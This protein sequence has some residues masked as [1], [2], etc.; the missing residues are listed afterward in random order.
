MKEIPRS[1]EFP[2]KSFFLFGPR[3]V[4]KSSLLRRKLS[5]VSISIDLLEFDMSLDL[6]RNPG[7]LESLCGNLKKGDWIWIDEVQKVPNL[8]D[9]VHRLIE[10]RSWNFALSGSSA[11]KLKR[12]GANLLA[13]RALTRNLE[14]FTSFEL[15]DF[16]DL[17]DSLEYGTL[18]L[19]TTDPKNRTETLSAYVN[20]YIR[21]EI[22]EEGLVRKVD[23]FLRFLEIAGQLNGEQINSS[24]LAREARI[25]R[26]N[27]DVYFSILEDTLLGH[28][29]R[30]Y[31][32]KAKVKEQ[33]HPK[34]YWFDSGVARTAAGYLKETLEA[35]WIGKAL[36]TLLYHELR[37]Y[38]HVSRKERGIYFYKVDKDI[39]I[40]FVIETKKGTFNSQPE[41]V[42][43]EVKFAK[44][45]D[46]RWERPMQSLAS[47][48]KVKVK[49]MYG[50]Y[51]GKE[52]Y[53][54]GNVTILP[55]LEFLSRLHKGLI[56]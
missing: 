49:H 6:S 30:A 41:I 31:R 15:G 18:P 48:D 8:L 13:G 53:H 47:S 19:V 26:S 37:V 28:W 1:L 35:T 46:N 9:E 51:M 17:K 27:V 20:T 29:L 24:N 45:W 10:K 34:F 22:K 11:R 42:L 2:D 33:T 54:L 36:E 40:D 39:E 21:E 23:P 43:I 38:N 12:G 56:F 16:F 25:S 7:K 14:G 5:Q 55:V 3:G 4:G 50:V 52:T 32:L 44:K